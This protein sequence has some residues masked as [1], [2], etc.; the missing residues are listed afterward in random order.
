EKDGI[1]RRL[2][3]DFGHGFP[4]PRGHFGASLGRHNKQTPGLLWKSDSFGGLSNFWSC[5]LFP[6]RNEEFEGW[7]FGYA[8]LKPNYAA[9]AD[10]GGLAGARDGLSA[11]FEEDFLTRPPIRLTALSQR[12]LDCL[13]PERV[14]GSHRILSGA[15]RLAVETRPD[16][17]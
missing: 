9:I 6:F 8:D 17:E 15:N 14:A 11:A 12:L 13:G 7:P 5:W 16:A 10:A 3:R 2:R 1:H 4:P